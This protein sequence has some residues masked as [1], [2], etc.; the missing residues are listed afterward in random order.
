M[1]TF[2][3]LLATTA[4]GFA[5]T[6]P[7]AVYAQVGIGTA[8]PD[9]SAL[10]DLSST[11]KGLLVPRMSEAQ[12]LVIVAPAKALLVFQTD[13]TQPG[14][15]YNAGT[16]GT[17]VWTFF[18]PAADNLGNHLA[19][20]DV[21][22]Q[23]NA[24][25]GAGS[26]IGTAIGLGVTA[27]GGLNIGQNTSGNNV[28]LGYGAGQATTTG[29]T[30]LFVGYNSG[31]A[32]LTGSQNHF[33][34]VESG[35]RNEDGYNNQFDGFQSGRNNRAGHDN[36]FLGLQSGYSNQGGNKNFFA[37][38]ESGYSTVGGHGNQFLGYQS[39]RANISGSSNLYIGFES[40]ASS[41]TS[42]G[43]HFVG[44]QSGTNTVSSF[45]HFSGAFS[46]QANISGTKNH[47]EG[48]ASGKNN[49]KGSDNHFVGYNAG[50][51]NLEA[52]NNH[53]DGYKSGYSNQGGNKNFFAGYESGYA[54]IGGHGNQF[55]GYRSGHAN[56]SGSSNLYIGFESGA[57]SVSTLGN[58]FVGYLS[59]TNTRSSFNHFSGAF[60]GQANTTGSSNHFEGHAS[61]KNNTKGSDNQ[62]VGYYAG[63]ANV[64]GDKN[65]AF[66]YEAGPTTPN[67]TNAGAIGYQAQV[68]QSNSLALGGTGANA[69]KV[70]I[71]T[72][73]PRGLLDVAG[74]GHSY[75]VPDP[76]TG[77]TQA[78]YAPGNLWLAPFNNT[79]MAYIQARRPNNTGDL[80]LTLR[81]MDNG[82]VVNALRL[83]ADGSA[84]FAGAVT[85]VSFSPSDQRLKQ[86]IRPLSGALAAVQ[87]L[88][89]VRYT[90]R[91]HL[92][93]QPLPPGEQVGVLA[94]EVEKIYPELVS[95]GPDGYKAVNYAQ[96]TPVLIE[97]IK[98]LKAEND[99]L[100]QLHQQDQAAAQAQASG[101]EQRLRALEAGGA[102]AGR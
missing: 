99:Q 31:A 3:A 80:A 87:A 28:F 13:G 79:N 8:T 92:P 30:N 73:A 75:L 16:A 61:G 82:A 71:G 83:N 93:G 78:L 29:S 53:F 46:G 72:T 10:L 19:T 60:S 51:H 100:R 47:F 43:N 91:Q 14:F 18:N 45:N 84:V 36:L 35:Y 66:G 17:P 81:T 38:H 6:G 21:R 65:W 2:K 41:T 54:N 76:N 12:R 39:G 67:L 59:G 62:F 9:A 48:H 22:L 90:Y 89:G 97:A 58:H 50:Y 37:G 68:S 5:L 25:T 49:T 86:G 74:S 96:L 33:V 26:S 64:D 85:A 69:V 88:R 42:L 34:G 11:A 23:G 7:A 55:L 44:Y 101:F 98:E 56:A 95:T 20:Q 94:Q 27:A 15:W 77:N 52:D 57:S 40:G 1:R 102:Q 24:L 4:L 70:G 63:E 32:N